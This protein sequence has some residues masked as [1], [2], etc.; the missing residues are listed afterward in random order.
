MAGRGVAARV[1]DRRGHVL[2]RSRIPR[3]DRR[4]AQHRWLSACS[5]FRPGAPADVVVPQVLVRKFADGTAAVTVCGDVDDAAVD[6]HAHAAPRRRCAVRRAIGSNPAS[7]S[8][9]IWPPSSRHATPSAPERSTKAVIARPI[10]VHSSEPIDVHAVLR[11]LRSQLRVELP[12]LDRRLH[13]CLPRA[14]RGSRRH[15]SCARIHLPAPR[16]G[17]VT[18]TTTPGSPPISSRARRT[19]SSTA[20]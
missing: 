11:R 7:T 14:P 6:R 5:A 12:V 8:T 3:L 9:T 1:A 4:R 17:R 20:S 18:S 10:V 13:R 19:R 2:S 15:R 16:P